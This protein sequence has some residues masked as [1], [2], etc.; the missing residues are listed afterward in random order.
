MNLSFNYSNALVAQAFSLHPPFIWSRLA[1]M[2]KN[3]FGIPC[4]A[5]LFKIIVN[6]SL[7]IALGKN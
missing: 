4:F 7:I 6:Y 2:C 3:L 1:E 5:Y